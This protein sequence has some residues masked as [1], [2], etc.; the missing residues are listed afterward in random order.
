LRTKQMSGLSQ[1]PAA[2]PAAAPATGTTGGPVTETDAQE[3]IRLRAAVTSSQPVPAAPEGKH[4]AELSNLVEHMFVAERTRNQIVHAL[5]AKEYESGLKRQSDLT[6]L[7]ET[8]LVRASSIGSATTRTKVIAAQLDA[9][10]IN[11]FH[12]DR[13]IEEL[14]KRLVDAPAPPGSPSPASPSAS[15]KTWFESDEGALARRELDIVR[16]NLM[17]RSRE[18]TVM[19]MSPSWNVATEA[20]DI[21]RPA[22]DE[23]HAQVQAAI[24][25]QEKKQK[26]SDRKRKAQSDVGGWGQAQA[27]RSATSGGG[28]GQG[29]AP[30]PAQSAIVPWSAQNNSAPS[31][32]KGSKGGKGK[33]KGKS[34][35]YQPPQLPAQPAP[36]A[37]FN[38]ME[39][40]PQDNQLAIPEQGYGG[41]LGSNTCAYCKQEGHWK[42]DCPNRQWDN[43]KTVDWY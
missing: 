35:G 19:W 5:Q 34:K 9:V 41:P 43:W 18:L 33:G 42:N 31:T 11:L 22:Q 32:G 7:R 13:A 4:I 37:S 10:E 39:A 28:W 1:E 29:P 3:L 27:P 2:Q 14:G 16:E 17:A 40:W 26:E 20:L 6:A 38:G 12:L 25:V 24:A 36:P 30:A 15:V 8:Q 23:V 21:S